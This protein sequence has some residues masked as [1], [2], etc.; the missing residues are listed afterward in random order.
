MP[1]LSRTFSERD[2]VKVGIVGIVVIGLLGALL[3]NSVSIYEALT[4]TSYTAQFLEVGGLATGNPV[5]VNGAEVGKVTDVALS[6]TCDCAD[7]TF[8]ITNAA[9]LGDATRAAITADTILGNRS[10]SIYPEGPGELEAGATIPVGRTTSPYDL[11]N[12]LAT[13]T[14]KAEQLNQ[15]D[16]AKALDTIATTF[17][18]SP[19]PL[20]G[21]LTAV[22][23]LLAHANSVTGV[24]GRRSTDLV[25][26][27]AEGRQLLAELNRRQNDLRV[28]FANVTRVVDELRGLV[29]DNDDQLRPALEKLEETLDLLERNDKNIAAIVHG[30]KGYTGGLGE[31][32][33]GGPWFFAYLQNLGEAAALLGGG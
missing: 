4:R 15:E 16:L 17:K 21:T 31:A 8:R 32:I 28:L 30:L 12:A 7:V 33:G 22:R 10:L 1:L 5:R 23:E 26:I 25:R 6:D 18:D 14:D 2:P 11:T 9:R 29:R 27:A 13:L 24:L 19:T 3:Y 20:R